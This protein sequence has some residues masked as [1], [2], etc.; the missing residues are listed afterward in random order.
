VQET[1]AY[2]SLPPSQWRG[3]YEPP[4]APPPQPGTWGDHPPID[5][6]AEARADSQAGAPLAAIAVLKA[7]GEYGGDRVAG[8][9]AGLFGPMFG[10][11]S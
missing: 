11:K 7:A 6:M 3:Y 4:E 8:A 1:N 2:A 10:V 5:I 9:L